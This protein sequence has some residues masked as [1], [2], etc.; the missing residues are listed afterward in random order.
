MDAFDKINQIYNTFTHKVHEL[1][2]TY[3]ALPRI[4]NRTLSCDCLYDFGRK[5]TNYLEFK[6]LSLFYTTFNII[7]VDK[8]HC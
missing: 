6:H 2:K 1:Q 3:I 7:N 5:K 4:Y 8:S